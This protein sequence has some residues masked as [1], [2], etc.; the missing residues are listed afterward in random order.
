MNGEKIS[1]CLDAVPES[2]LEEAMKPYKPHSFG[3]HLVKIAACLALVVALLISYGLGKHGQAENMC[4]LTIT[5]YALDS[6]ST[7]KTLQPGVA[8][9]YSYTWNPAISAVPGLPLTLSIASE[10]Y[11]SDDISFHVTLDGGS[12]VQWQG[13]SGWLDN[14]RGEAKQLPQTFTLS[15]NSTIYWRCWSNERGG[16]IQFE[17]DTA[18][19]DIIIYEKDAI[20]GYA[21]LKLCRVY[22]EEYGPTNT[23][24]ASLVVSESFQD[25]NTAVSEQHVRIL[26]AEAK[27]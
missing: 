2:M 1:R 5:V 14:Y 8:L 27:S 16:A 24:T 25:A 15:N 26:I 10:M 13:H 9:P 6:N 22:S 4:I 11:L 3:R 7:A 19:A 12:F 20:I 17:G 21:V 18:Y 23:F